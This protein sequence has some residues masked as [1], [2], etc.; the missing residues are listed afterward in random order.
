MKVEQRIGRIDRL[1]QRFETVRII[2]LMYKDTVETDVYMALRTRSGLFGTFVG[3]LQPILSS[4]PKTFKEL[5]LHAGDDAAIKSTEAV[6]KITANLEQQQQSGFDLDE[7][8]PEDLEMPERPKP[9]YDMPYLGQVLGNPGLL[10]PGYEATP[11]AGGKDYRYF[12]PG[13]K[14][15]IR[16]TTDPEYYEQHTESV[17]LWSPGSPAFP[18]DE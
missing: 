15:A 16:V 9:P 7:I 14:E 5:T 12:I 8:Q 11:L 18:W 17:E 3:K 6:E 4:L 1:G 2:N 13:H 10:P